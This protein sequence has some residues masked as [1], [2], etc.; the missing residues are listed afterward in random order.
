MQSPMTNDPKVPRK[1]IRIQ[2]QPN[3]ETL[4]NDASHPNSAS[5][6]LKPRSILKNRNDGPSTPV[7][8]LDPLQCETYLLGP[9]RTLTVSVGDED[10]RN[11]S[12]HDVTEAYIL[13]S[14]RIEAQAASLTDDSSPAV[15]AVRNL[16]SHLICAAIRRDVSRAISGASE[17]NDVSFS[18][19]D[20]TEEERSRVRDRSSICHASLRFLANLVRFPSLYRSFKRKLSHSM[21]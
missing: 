9:L 8:V 20:L 1:S 16:P 7:T 5:T 11:V 10:R 6:M 17:A 13:L 4:S 15:A 3:A 2:A 14:C 21:H 12:L 18:Q 19:G